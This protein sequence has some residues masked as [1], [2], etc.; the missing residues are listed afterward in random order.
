MIEWVCQSVNFWVFNLITLETA[1]LLLSK[2]RRVSVGRRPK[3]ER[4]EHRRGHRKF[5]L[6]HWPPKKLPPDMRS[7]SMLNLYV[8]YM[9]IYEYISPSES[10]F[11][12][13][14]AEERLLAIIIA[15]NRIWSSQS[16][17]SASWESPP[18]QSDN[19]RRAISWWFHITTPLSD[20]Q[21][22]GQIPPH[23]VASDGKGGLG[24]WGSPPTVWAQLVKVD[25][26][27][28]LELA[29]D[30]ANNRRRRTMV[31]SSA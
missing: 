21:R 18:G 17:P 9:E 26:S 11:S 5:S 12:H 22:G 30:S 29:D 31:Y 27:T 28:N 4:T 2:Q 16:R 20:T 24:V 1:L 8:V 15:P 25:H 7:G 3:D 23:R 19:R 10:H 14:V 6:G 13:L